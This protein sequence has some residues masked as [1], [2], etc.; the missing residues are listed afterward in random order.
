MVIHPAYI[1]CIL[2]AGILCPN[3]LLADKPERSTTRGTVGT[4]RPLLKTV[5]VRTCH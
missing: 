5:Q 2:F 4:L 1:A 3:G